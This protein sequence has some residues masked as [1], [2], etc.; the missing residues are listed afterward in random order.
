[1]RTAQRSARRHHVAFGYLIVDGQ[2]KA[3]QNK[4]V[5]TN[6]LFESL[7]TCPL[8]WIVG[9]VI[10]VIGGV[11][12]VDRGPVTAVPDLSN[13]RRT[14]RLLSSIDIGALP[15]IRV[16]QLLNAV[17]AIPPLG[18]TTRSRKIGGAVWVATVRHCT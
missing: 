16:S 6:P 4:A 17:N 5:S 7:R 10:H 9:I 1:M 18:S 8:V 12:L 13:C 2:V 15:W 3:M 14:S 11:Q